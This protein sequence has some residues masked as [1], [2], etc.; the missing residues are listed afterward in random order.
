MFMNN[1]CHI[2]ILM[3][4]FVLLTKKSK[5]TTFV[6]ICSLRWLYGV[7][8]VWFII[9]K[10]LRYPVLCGLNLP[11]EV[12]LYWIEHILGAL[13]GPLTLTLSGRFILFDS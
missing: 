3:Q 11:F 9:T 10:A 8:L 13:I 1:P 6:F 5:F 2:V 7:F 12:E 4:G